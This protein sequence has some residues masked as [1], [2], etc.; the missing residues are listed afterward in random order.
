MPDY[1]R[2]YVPGGTYF[3]TVVTHL[4]RPFLTSELAR[5]CLHAAF[6]K[7]RGKSPF[8][9]VAIVLL[10]DHWHAVW[11]L[12]PGDSRFSLR[13]RQIKETFTR[14]YLAGGGTELAQS[15]SRAQHGMR[16]IWQKRFWEHTIDDDD[17]C[18]S[19]L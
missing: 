11:T 10:P 9:I 8:E 3:F 6:D 12:P 13:L 2:N 17:D 14:S 7:I 18:H 16:G 19:A 15:R 1:R 4:R 5:S